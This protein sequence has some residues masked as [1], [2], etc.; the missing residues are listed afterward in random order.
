MKSETKLARW[1]KAQGGPIALSKRLGITPHTIRFWTRGKGWPT[2]KQGRKLVT[3]SKGKLTP[4][5]IFECKGG[6]LR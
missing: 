3:F 4:R 1:V 6:K 2:M 5:D